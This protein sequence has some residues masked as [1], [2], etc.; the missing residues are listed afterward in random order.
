MA[1]ICSLKTWLRL[2]DYRHSLRGIVPSAAHVWD[3]SAPAVSPSN[4]AKRYL[5]T[6]CEIDRGQ[7]EWAIVPY[8][9]FP[10]LG[11]NWDNCVRASIPP[12]HF[13]GGAEARG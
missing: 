1:A 9:R 12:P 3:N 2:W 7:L 6:S 11:D 4:F 13:R 5:P 10:G 8:N